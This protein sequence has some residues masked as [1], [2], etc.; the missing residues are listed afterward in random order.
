MEDRELTRMVGATIAMRRKRLGFTQAQLS[1][2]LGISQESLSRMEKGLISPK[3][4]RLPMFAR[5]LDCSIPSLFRFTSEDTHSKAMTIAEMLQPLSEE[6]QMAVVNMVAD[7]I[8]LMQAE[9]RS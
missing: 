3:F 1:E 8:K 9:A 4:S 2:K 7:I 5:A 6:G